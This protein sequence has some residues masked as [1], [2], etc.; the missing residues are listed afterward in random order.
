MSPIK[1]IVIAAAMLSFSLHSPDA[2]FAEAPDL[3]RQAPGT[4]KASPET[5]PTRGRT[6]KGAPGA[7]KEAPPARSDRP[8]GKSRPSDLVIRHMQKIR[9][10]Q[11]QVTLANIGSGGVPAEAYDR[12]SSV[13][14]LASSSSGRERRFL[15][16]IDPHRRLTRP[17]STV[18]FIGFGEV[19]GRGEGGVVTLSIVD[20]RKALNESNTRNNSLKG[21]IRLAGKA[22]GAEAGLKRPSEDRQRLKPDLVVRQMTIE[23]S[24]PTTA[25]EIRFSAFVSNVGQ[26]TAGAS[27]AAIR[28]G[29]ET[30]PAQFSKP[31]ISPGSSEAVVRL[32]QLDRPGRY[33][34]IFTADA[35]GQVQESNEGNNQAYLEFEVAQA[36][37]SPPGQTAA[38]PDTVAKDVTGLPKVKPEFPFAILEEQLL[39]YTFNTPGTFAMYFKASKVIDLATLSPSPVRVDISYYRDGQL[40]SQ[41]ELP[42]QIT[43]ANGM[44]PPVYPSS[45]IYWKSNTTH[46]PHACTGTSTSYCRFDVTISD[47]LLSEHGESLD[48][49]GDGQPGGQYR[50]TF[51]RGNGQP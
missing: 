21:T 46:Y 34:V 35:S 41:Q 38:A 10:G 39:T 23:P 9:K 4:V 19:L 51:Y 50:H 7:L 1:H 31:A 42:G 48:G 25:D 30:R 44:G 11:I 29:G 13:Y 43:E 36:P 40:Q 17:G 14:V 24:N 20:R 26:W 6:L 32:G 5:D 27:K 15:S 37:V 45:R 33:R 8:D 28:I 12:R 2:L 18:R 3:R 49:D 22:S 16:D 47:S